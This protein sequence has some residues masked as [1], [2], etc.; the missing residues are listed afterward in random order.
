MFL[1]LYINLFLI[2]VFFIVAG[3]HSRS[4]ES[5]PLST[6][7]YPLNSNLVFILFED[8]QMNDIIMFKVEHTS[9]NTRPSREHKNQTEIHIYVR[10]KAKMPP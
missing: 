1:S 5:M 4:T 6:D 10:I 2:I 3:S 7:G 9:H 8:L